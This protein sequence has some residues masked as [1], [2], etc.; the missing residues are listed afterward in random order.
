M[1][2]RVLVSL[3]VL[4]FTCGTK[5]VLFS[6]QFDSREL[7]LSWN[8]LL[9]LIFF[10]VFSNVMCNSCEAGP[11]LA[12]LERKKMKISMSVGSN[13]MHLKIRITFRMGECYNESPYQW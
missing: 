10:V 7:L 9:K 4:L 6:L 11:N 2:L 5:L 1:K 3:R 8:Q 13:R 12:L